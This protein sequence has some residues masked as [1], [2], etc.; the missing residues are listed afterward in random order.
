M[1]KMELD[2]L[3]LHCRRALWIPGED[4]MDICTE[5]C[6]GISQHEQSRPDSLMLALIMVTITGGDINMQGP[7]FFTTERAP[8][9]GEPCCHHHLS[10]CKLLGLLGQLQLKLKRSKRAERDNPVGKPT[11]L[12]SSIF[13]NRRGVWCWQECSGK[14]CPWMQTSHSVVFHLEYNPQPARNMVLTWVW[15]S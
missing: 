15:I 5:V 1:R 2:L 12:L 9:V 6:K 10:T 4:L 13:F 14:G 3:C 7:G 8:V 11:S